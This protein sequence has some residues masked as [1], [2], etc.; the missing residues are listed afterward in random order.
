[1]PREAC[2]SGGGIF[3]IP[4][5]STT[6]DYRPPSHP[7]SGLYMPIFSNSL[8]VS[9]DA[10]GGVNV[11]RVKSLVSPRLEHNGLSAKL[12]ELEFTRWRRNAG[13]DSVESP[14]GDWDWVAAPRPPF[15]ELV[16]VVA[17]GDRY[18]KFLTS[19]RTASSKNLALSLSSL[20]LSRA[21]SW[22]SWKDGY[23]PWGEVGRGFGMNIRHVTTCLVGSVVQCGSQDTVAESERN[24]VS[25][26]HIAITDDPAL[27][28]CGKRAGRH[29][30]GWHGTGWPNPSR[31]TKFSSANRGRSGNHAHIQYQ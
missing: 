29:K 23:K 2:T 1:M 11:R 6:K 21:S 3:S 7:R 19:R 16:V 22:I 14:A 18:T 4:A 26:H 24:L 20:A 8:T 15:G 5:D 25:K 17:T 31:V 13:L 9:G 12:G 27:P 30:T 10:K 28:E